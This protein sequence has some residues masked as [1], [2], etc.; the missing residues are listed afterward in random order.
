MLYLKALDINKKLGSLKIMASLY[1]SLGK[2]YQT[3]REFDK[4]CEYWHKS[5]KLFTDI[6]AQNKIGVVGGWIAESCKE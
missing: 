6:G 1:G 4:A 5:L 2:V 3:R